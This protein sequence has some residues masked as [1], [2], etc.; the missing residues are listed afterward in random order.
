[1]LTPQ[2]PVVFANVRESQVYSTNDMSPTIPPQTYPRHIEDIPNQL[3]VCGFLFLSNMGFFSSQMF[4][5]A[6]YF[7]ILVTG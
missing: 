7:F 5:S 3:F 4:L 6:L 1:M 2:D